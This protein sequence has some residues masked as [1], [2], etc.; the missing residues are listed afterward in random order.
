[1]VQLTEKQKYEIIVRNELGQ[2]S[3]QISDKM[4]I[5]RK[6]ALKW[7]K[8]YKNEESIKREK[9]SGRKRK[10]NKEDD[11]VIFGEMVND[12]PNITT[13]EIQ[14]NLK[15]KNINLSTATIKKRLKEND[16]I[17]GEVIEKPLLTINHKQLRLKW[18]I[19]YYNTDWTT[20]KFSDETMI[21]K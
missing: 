18:A 3:R 2:S 8:K 7:I 19:E 12:D 6:S 9:G 20:I 1:M 21:R 5:N 17:Y 13:N 14:I 4:K 11:K 15:D 16:F 10:T